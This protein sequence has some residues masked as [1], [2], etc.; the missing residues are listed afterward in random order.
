[1]SARPLALVTGG[2]RGIG[3]AACQALAARGFDILCADID[4]EGAA[5]TGALVQAEGASF[6]FR[7]FDLAELGSHAALVAAASAE[8]RLACL[9]NNAGVGALRRGDLLDV[10]VESW[11]RAQGINARGSFFLTQAVAKAMIASPASGPRSIVFVSSANAVLASPDRGEYCASKAAVSMI[12]K[13]FAV[14]LAEEGIAVH[15]IR[16]GVIRTEMT[17]PVAAR[18]EQRIAGGLSPMRRWG[19]AS[20]IG[21]TIAMLAAGDLPF[22]TGDALHVDGGLHLGRL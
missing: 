9:V 2:R 20:D 11:D 3:R 21:R 17:A 14:R 1:M 5:E 22:S 16:P 8:G 6:A 13:V 15:E 4:E 18:Y 7:R 12:A 10:S 19:E